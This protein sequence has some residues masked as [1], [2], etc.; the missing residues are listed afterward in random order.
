MEFC[1]KDAIAYVNHDDD[2]FEFYTQGNYVKNMFD[3]VFFTLSD[4]NGVS[5]KGR[6]K[7]KHVYTEII[8]KCSIENSMDLI[9]KL[10]NKNVK[11]NDNIYF[12]DNDDS[13]LPKDVCQIL[14][15]LNHLHNSR[16]PKRFVGGFLLLMVKFMYFP[17]TEA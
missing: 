16:V 2:A 14:R 4:S 11:S 10:L 15:F 9:Y 3:R 12:I 6:A 7:F 8:E 5:L 13:E 17:L 1:L